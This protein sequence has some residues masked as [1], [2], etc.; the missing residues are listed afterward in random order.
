MRIIQFF[1]IALIL[2]AL[3]AC[4][5]GRKHFAPVT[6]IST[7]DVIPRTG[8]YEVAR[9]DTIYSI[10]WRYGLDYRHLAKLNGI[11]SPY[12]IGV[13]QIIRLNNSFAPIRQ[14]AGATKVATSKKVSRKKVSDI[15]SHKH[16]RSRSKSRSIVTEREPT[17]RVTRWHWPARGPIVG[18]FSSLNKGINIAGR[19][20]DPIFSTAT[21]KVV[22]SGNGLRGYGNLII[23]KHNNLYLTA[24]AHN[25]AM[26]VKEGAWVKRG[27]KIATMGNTGTRRVMLHFEIRRGGQ[28]MN[29]LKYLASR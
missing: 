12:H 25:N 9:G 24:Y 27:Q 19:K 5:S 29:P 22:Y 8:G 4:A 23:I 28:P 17:Q 26:L 13:G 7:I 6:E 1:I 3:T 20:G 11:Q 14:Q 16:K 21:G 10:A 2:C 18:R 15:V